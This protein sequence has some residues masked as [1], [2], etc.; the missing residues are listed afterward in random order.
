MVTKIT[1]LTPIQ[2]LALKVL[3]EYKKADKVI[4]EARNV[5]R[6][7]NI[8][9]EL[10]PPITDD[11]CDAVVSLC[12]IALCAD[13]TAGDGLANYFLYECSRSGGLIVETD[14]TEW[15]IKTIDDLR[16]NLIY[17]ANLLTFQANM[18]VKK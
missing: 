7:V 14:G 17:R 15:R 13:H 2:E 12:D 4:L 9:A 10:Q 6:G 3:D 8:D 1:T 11:L 18:E 5:L 16:N